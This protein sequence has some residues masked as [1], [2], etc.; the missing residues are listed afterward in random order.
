MEKMQKGDLC[1]ITGISGYLASWIGKYLLEEGYRVKGTVRSL[2]NQEQLEQMR[3]I[4]PGAEFVAADLRKEEGWAEAMKGV[5]WVFHVASPQ[6]V[7]TESDRTGGATKGTEYVMNAAFA[8]DT[9]QKIVVTSSEAAV[10]YGHPASKVYFNEEDW[11]DT[12]V[13]KEDYMKS[14]TLAEKLAW[15][16][17]GDKKR[18]P[19]QVPLSTVCPGQILG[20]SLIP[21]ARYSSGSLKDM[22]EGKT[23]FV[24]DMLSH[25][26]D[27]RDCARMHIAVMSNSATDGRRHLSFST[28]GRLT[29]IPHMIRE[30]YGHLGFKPSPRKIP[31]FVLWALRFV[32]GDVDTIYSRIGTTQVYQTQY[33]DV[34]RYQYTEL[35]QMVRDTLESM[36]E[37]GML[38]PTT[39]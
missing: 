33:P 28:K 31:K 35:R 25:Y 32:N 27:V 16:L 12:R 20:P 3:R 26:V 7:K 8:A 21:W 4:L 19:R 13:A 34:Y 24:F 5:Q 14:K 2:S 30:D 9:V 10:A 23:P 17:A 38:A 18:N 15:E 39:K 37:N 36:M 11:T 1:L 22:A 6:A 29:E